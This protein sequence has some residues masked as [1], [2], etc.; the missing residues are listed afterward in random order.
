MLFRDKI[1][2]SNQLMLFLDRLNHVGIAHSLVTSNSDRTEIYVE[3]TPG[4]DSVA[5]I[6]KLLSAHSGLSRNMWGRK[7]MVD[8]T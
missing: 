1:T 5:E 6:I 7:S 8:R 3:H 4:T 2:I